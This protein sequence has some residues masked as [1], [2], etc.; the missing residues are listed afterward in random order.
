MTV[1]SD[2]SI[3]YVFVQEDEDHKTELPLGVMVW[4]PDAVVAA[5]SVTPV[6]VAPTR[7]IVGGLVAV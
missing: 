4:H 3:E 2:G 1:L 6:P 5:V 7:F